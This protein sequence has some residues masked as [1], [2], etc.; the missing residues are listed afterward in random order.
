MSLGDGSG[1]LLGSVVKKFHFGFLGFVCVWAGLAR[2]QTE[3][4]KAGSARKGD[5]ERSSALAAYDAGRFDDAK[6][7]LNHISSR[8]ENDF[9][10]QEALGLSYAESGETIAALPH[11]AAAAAVRPK[12]AGAQSNLG[13]AY[14]QAKKLPEAVRTLTVAAALDGANPGVQADLGH[15][16]FLNGQPGPAAEA[17]GKASRLRPEDND[18]RFDWAVALDASHQSQAAL[19]LLASFPA[20]GRTA[21]V[22]SLWG[23]VAEHAGHFQEAEQHMQQ[24]ARLDP[25]E[26]NLYALTV[27]LLRHWTWQAAGEI[28]DYGLKSFPESQRLRFAKGVSLYGNTQF[29]QAAEVFA[30]LLQ[31]APDNLTYGD[32]LGRSCTALGG[33]ESGSCGALI[34]LAKEHPENARLAVFAAINILHQPDNAGKLTQAEALLREAI[35]RDPTYSEAFYQL[36]VLQQDQQ[37]WADSADSLRRAIALRPAYAEAHYRLSRA[38]AHTGQKQQALGELA[39]QKQY[40]QQEKEA[41]DAQLKQVTIFLTD[42]H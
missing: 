36:G 16:L 38:Y 19:D 33:A 40:A 30:G 32:L 21:P 7:L 34:E 4:A 3:H 9:A 39:L 31:V 10:V 14:L 29:A 28:A 13:A 41:A 18:V 11:L 6:R 2:A 23:D 27:E 42:T 37:R 12:D 35:S 25:S 22:E 1:R 17:L 5:V 24:A 8:Y 20:T 26:P 15:A